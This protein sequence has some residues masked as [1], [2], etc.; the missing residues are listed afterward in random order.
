MP[1]VIRHQ[2]LPLLGHAMWYLAT[3]L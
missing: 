3:A 1:I 2:R